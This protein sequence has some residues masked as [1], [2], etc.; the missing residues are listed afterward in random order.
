ML[1]IIYLR[2]GKIS[3]ISLYNFSCISI[4]LLELKIP[5][6]VSDQHILASPNA[7]PNA[8]KEMGNSASA[9]L[10]KDK[11]PGRDKPTD[12]NGASK[13]P[14]LAEVETFFESLRKRG[15]KRAA[16]WFA[17]YGQDE[18]WSTR[19]WRKSANRWLFGPHRRLD[20]QP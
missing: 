19:D 12:S 10:S 5:F 6:G 7:S 20:A 16:E 9:L 3:K 17:N 4:H 18:K 11:E 14:T 13:P 2:I 8:S 1:G 15:S